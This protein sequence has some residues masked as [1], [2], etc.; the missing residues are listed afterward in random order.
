MSKTNLSKLNLNL[1]KA[2]D[3]LLREQ[4]VSKAGESIGL[5]Q[6]AMSIILKQLREI[7]RDDLLVRGQRSRM[8]LTPFA[9]T[10][11]Q[12]VSQALL[13]VEKVL[14][15]PVT[16]NP[17]LSN[18]T[19]HIG[20]SDYLAFI[21]LPKIIKRLAMEAPNI[22]IVQHAVNYFS[23]VDLFEN[24]KLDMVVG[25]FDHAPASIKVTRL[26][27]DKSVI[28]ADKNHPAL[29]KEKLTIQ[30]FIAYPQV[31]VALEGQPEKNFIADM[32]TEKGYQFKIALMTPH[33]LI[34]LQ[35]LPGTQ[36]MTNTV[37]RLAAPFLKNLGLKMV[38]T[39]YSMPDYRA[40]LYWHAKDHTDASHEW[41]RHVIQDIA[42]SL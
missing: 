33:T 14:S 16:F 10:L 13:Q 26:F 32:L 17:K 37:E 28:V 30:E 27:S 34:A 4:H 22:K 36:L 23:D 25:H 9:K 8:L 7:Y 42:R 31:F 6:S 11:L 18:R 15:L 40:R 29:K 2:L 21:L 38:D 41:L 3:A 20:M 1:L 5:T 35:A 39:P 24:G 19:F 12:P